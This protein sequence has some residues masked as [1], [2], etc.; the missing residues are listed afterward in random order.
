VI[1]DFNDI[2]FSREKEGGNRRPHSFMKAFQDALTDC[3]L[4]D[5]DF[6]GDKYTWNRGIIRE[7]LDRAV[8]N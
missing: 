6:L 1:G 7:R 3:E 8:A 4:E 2:L 5:I